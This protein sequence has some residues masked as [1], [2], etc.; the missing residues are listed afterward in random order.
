MARVEVDPEAG[1]PFDRSQS[2]AGGDEVVGDLSRVQ[3]EAEAA[4]FCVEHVHDRA[5][6]PGEILVAALDGGEV[7]GR[8]R[9]EE[10]PDRRAGEPVHLRDPKP[11][12]GARRVLHP[13][14]GALPHALRVAVAPDL[15]RQDRLVARVDR[16][17]DGLADEVGADREAVQV[18]A[19]EHLLHRPDVALLGERSVDLEMVSPAGELEPVEA[20]F[21]R[22]AREL[23]ERQVGPLAGEQGDGPRHARDTKPSATKGGVMERVLILTADSGEELEVYYMLY[24]FREAGYVVDVAAPERKRLQLV[25]HDFEAGADTYVER[26]GRGLDADLAFAEVDP[27]RYVALLIPGG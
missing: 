5:P 11:S 18:V 24:R 14:R 23:L 4:S 22:L 12:G 16:V 13:L 1:P 9:V 8:E 6:A 15:G 17:A 3:L 10:M 7:V 25:V 2:L 19:L 20:P 21:A 26:P 27:A